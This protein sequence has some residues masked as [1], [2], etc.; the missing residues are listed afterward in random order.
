M[1]EGRPAYYGNKTVEEIRNEL[2]SAIVTGADFITQIIIHELGEALS[3]Q[4]IFMRVG[5]RVAGKRIKE[6]MAPYIGTVFFLSFIGKEVNYENIRKVLL[7]LDVEPKNRFMEF[8][9]DIDLKNNV[10]AYGPAI[11][12]LKLNNLEIN[13]LNI[14]NVV[15]AMG[16]SPD[17]STAKHVFELYKEYAE[18][19][20]KSG[21]GDAETENELGKFTENAAKLEAAYMVWELDR[22]LEHK[23]IEKYLKR[24]LIPYLI[25]GGV[26]IYAGEEISVIGVERFL[27]YNANLVRALGIAVDPGMLDFMKSM[28][29]QYTSGFHCIPAIY[30]LLS[31]GMEVNVESIK[32]LV[33]AT[34]LS[35]D[36]TLISFAYTF[37]MD[38]K[39]R[40]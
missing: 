31:L 11:L 25:A 2:V 10:V 8:I 4:N 18:G 38:H 26:L 3:K 39:D 19:G 20:I 7:G 14:V 23:D 40:M 36:E 15:K 21:L 32:K 1:D 29:Y 5:M 22:T 33:D 27:E 17:P 34:G 37:Y 24:G 6:E 28:N 12:F 35:M 13:T 16:Y 9:A 30:L